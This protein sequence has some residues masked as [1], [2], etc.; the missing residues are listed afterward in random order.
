MHDHFSSC[1]QDASAWALG[2][3]CAGGRHSWS[4]LHA[5]GM[6]PKLLHLLQS[7]HSDVLTAAVYALTHFLAAGLNSLE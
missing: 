5:Q 3:L 7:P 4:L 6:L 1:L 2:N